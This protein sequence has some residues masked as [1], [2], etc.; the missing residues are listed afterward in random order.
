M[1]INLT[2]SEMTRGL[3]AIRD[4]GGLSLFADDEGAERIT[5][6]LFWGPLETRE[7]ANRMRTT[8]GW[9]RPD[10]PTSAAAIDHVDHRLTFFGRGAP[11]E[12]GLARATYC[13]LLGYSWPGW[14]VEYAHGGLH[15]IAAAVEIDLPP[16]A[17]S[18]PIE[19]PIRSTNIADVVRAIMRELLAGHQTPLRHRIARE[20]ARE[21]LGVRIVALR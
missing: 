19:E 9:P 6:L 3:Y 16:P 5:D 10:Q 2:E 21:R 15:E 7:R 20:A 12:S 8:S 13:E 14:T 4:E 17:L 18:P 11:L 1:A